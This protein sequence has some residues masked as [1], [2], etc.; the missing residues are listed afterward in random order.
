MKFSGATAGAS[1]GA[2]CY[3]AIY[4]FQLKVSL[5]LLNQFLRDDRVSLTNV[6]DSIHLI[7]ARVQRRRLRR[8]LQRLVRGYLPAILAASSIHFA[9]LSLFV[10]L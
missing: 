8:P 10:Y 6:K 3:S 7:K 9:K 2:P 1:A 5:L 4:L